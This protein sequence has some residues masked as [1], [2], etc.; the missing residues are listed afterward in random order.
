MFW[1]KLDGAV[2]FNKVFSYQ[3]PIDKV[4]IFNMKLDRDGPKVI[5]E[6]DLIGHLPDNPPIKWPK[7]YNKC[8]CGINCF[9]VSDFNCSG[10]DVNMLG[11]INISNGNKVV[12]TGEAFKLSFS[13][14]NIQL[15]GPSVYYD[16]DMLV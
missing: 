14:K 10:L 3:V 16:E 8:R 4:D 12:I 13:S 6:F 5:I 7:K 2:L 9:G 15:I 1:N 11:D